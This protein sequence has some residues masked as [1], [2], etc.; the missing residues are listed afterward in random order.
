MEPTLAIGIVAALIGI[1]AGV[2]QII[3]YIEKKKQQKTLIIVIPQN[4]SQ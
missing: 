2:V 4:Q 1:C 3:D